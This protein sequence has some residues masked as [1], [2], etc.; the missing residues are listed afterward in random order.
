[1]TVVYVGR[2]GPGLRA[3]SK[4]VEC[5]YMEGVVGRKPTIIHPVV[6]S[7]PSSQREIT[8]CGES[9]LISNL[10]PGS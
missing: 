1:M 8:K 7:P 6:P 9:R 3:Q 4:Q 5:V 2:E 10:S